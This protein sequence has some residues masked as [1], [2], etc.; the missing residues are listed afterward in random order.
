MSLYSLKNVT[1]MLEQ[2]GFETFLVGP[3]YLP[4]S[5]GAWDDRIEAFTGDPRNNDGMRKAYPGF[6]SL[7]CAWCESLGQRNIT[8][9]T[10][11]ILAIRSDYPRAAHM[12][13]GLG[14]C[15][16][17]TR[18]VRQAR[19]GLSPAHAGPPPPTPP[20]PACS[21]PPA[22]ASPRWTGPRHRLQTR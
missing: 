6:H 18:I 8:S 7:I 17:A 2:Q 20:L 3:R 4:L 16:Q 22:P 13:R 10:S 21:D 5:H 19:H 12:K 9:A 1:A 11:E 15:E 14:A